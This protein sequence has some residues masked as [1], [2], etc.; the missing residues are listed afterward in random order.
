[1][2]AVKSVTQAH[3]LIPGLFEQLPVWQQDFA[4]TPQSEVFPQLLMNAR[5][6]ALPVTG[7]QE[8][9]QYLCTSPE[10]AMTWAQARYAC[11]TGA[12]PRGDVLCADPVY[13]QSGIDQIVLAP[14]LPELSA[15]DVQA[16]LALLNPHLAQDG[17]RLEVLEQH[18]YLHSDGSQA[19]P[20]TTALQ[21]A[22]GNNIYPFLPQSADL[23]WQR[24]LNEV[25]MLLHSH[26]QDKVNALWLWGNESVPVRA[27]SFAFRAVQ[28][29]GVHGRVAA[30]ML[31]ALQLDTQALNDLL[32]IDDLLLP[33]LRE[34]TAAWQHALQ[35]VEA[36]DLAPLLAQWQR[37]ECDVHL[38]DGAGSVWQCQ[39]P[40]KWKFWQ[41]PN[42]DWYCIT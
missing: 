23:Y 21:T 29:G 5:R 16:I 6:S 37:G 18:W 35:A 28:G 33:A 14:E 26:P 15:S 38:Y 19:L 9:L 8:T 30:R 2:S 36:R 40:S 20:Q 32:I 13:L 11:D 31:S 42:H 25:Q 10:Q 17:L 12:L 24:L 4:F 34:D 39:R 7:F 22:M 27:E 3:L 41:K 1:M